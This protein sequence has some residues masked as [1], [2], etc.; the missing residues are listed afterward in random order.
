MKPTNEGEKQEYILCAAIQYHDLS[1]EV[2]S[3]IGLVVAGRRHHDIIHTT[4]FLTGKS[5]HLMGKNTQGFI[6]SKNRFL[7]RVEAANFFKDHG[8]EVTSNLLYSEDL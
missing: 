1:D 7:N 3:E 8:G 2:Y 4:F 5:Q 6:T